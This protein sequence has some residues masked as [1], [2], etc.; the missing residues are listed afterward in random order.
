[1][2][3]KGITLISLVI[4]II[5]LLI[6]AGVTM[7]VILGE[8]GVFNRAKQAKEETKRAQIIEYLDIKLLE[9]QSKHYLETDEKTNEEINETIIQ[10]TKKNV[11]RNKQDLEKIGKEVEIR[12]VE[13]QKGEIYFFVIV[14]RGIYK[15]TLEGTKYIGNK[16]DKEVE[17]KE[18]EI[19]FKYTPSGWTNENVKV[20]IINN[21]KEI[22]EGKIQYRKEEESEWKDYKEKIEV[23][24]NQ[25]IYAKIVGTLE[26]STVATGNVTKIDK[27]K[28]M[29]SITE[30]ATTAYENQTIT[31]T[32]EI[33]D[34]ESGINTSQSKWILNTD[35]TLELNESEYSSGTPLNSGSQ[36]ISL[37]LTSNGLYYLHVLAKDNA[38]N[39][40]QG[41][42]SKIT[43]SSAYSYTKAFNYTGGMQNVTIE[44][45][46]IYKLEVWGAS[47]A[48]DNGVGGKGGYSIGY[49]QLTKGDIIYIC[50]GGAGSGYTGGYNGG[51]SRMYRYNK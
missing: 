50:V 40:K 15:V 4:T 33:S 36:P 31:A 38:G 2:K 7:N 8:N 5:I 47:G 35:S 14:D 9:E 18:G 42:S 37:K 11:E 46:G 34:S 10:E 30:L 13:K 6:L 48:S 28:P 22:K 17:L 1:M 12:E 41:V 24:K 26:N 45:T 44:Q 23:E 3:N 16:I 20:E 43:V 19:E 29:V 25:K 49:K 32:V 51:G 39:I 27:I 21:N